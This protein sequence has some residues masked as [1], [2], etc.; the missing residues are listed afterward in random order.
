MSDVTDL[1]VNDDKTEVSWAVSGKT[2]RVSAEDIG[3]VIEDKVHKKIVV[4]LCKSEYPYQIKVFDVSG[5]EQFSFDEPK[6]FEFY[7]LKPHSKFGV[8]IVCTI[9]EPVDGRMD[10]QFEIN[11]SKGKLERYAP[12][13]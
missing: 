3:Q 10:W 11:Y 7:Y 6:P 12:S 5:K 1:I 9:N 2:I 8:S 4:S 13:F